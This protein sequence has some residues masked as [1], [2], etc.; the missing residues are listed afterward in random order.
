M[1]V[2][3]ASSLGSNDVARRIDA[4]RRGDI[5]VLISIDMVSEGFDLPEIEA[6]QML[7]PTASF[8][9]YRQMIGRAT[10][11]TM[12]EKSYHTRPR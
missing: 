1:H 3:K 4:F 5:T 2:H 12:Q 10:P 8:G 11:C 6:I 9:L 7:R